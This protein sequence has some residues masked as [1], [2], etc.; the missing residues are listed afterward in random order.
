[1]IKSANMCDRKKKNKIKINGI[2]LACDWDNNGNPVGLK[3]YATDETEYHINFDKKFLDFLKKPVVVTA[4]ELNESDGV[5]SL[6][7]LISI[8]VC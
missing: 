6:I 7:N 3:L 1:M 8:Q 4:A 2:I 5:L